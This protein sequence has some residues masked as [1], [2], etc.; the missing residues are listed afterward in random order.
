MSKTILITSILAATGI[1]GVW[2]W[3]APDSSARG[4]NAPLDNADVEAEDASTHRHRS[5]EPLHAT[6][7]ADGSEASEIAALRGDL[8]SLR[9]QVEA[10]G[11]VPSDFEAAPERIADPEG[12]AEPVEPPHPQAIA[13]AELEWGSDYASQLDDQLDIEPVDDAWAS[14]SETLA[15]QTFAAVGAESVVGAARC[16][17]TLCRVEIAHDGEGGHEAAVAALRD[18]RSW[19]GP[20][21]A[22]PVD[23]GRGPTTVVFLGRDGETLPAPRSSVHDYLDHG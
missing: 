7:S 17:S 6:P 3:S 12:T 13:D 10:D 11:G 4:R 16:R 15:R 19:P 14:E 22:I 5:G 23:D 1:G 20:F 8:R 2:M 18:D 21:I 9:A